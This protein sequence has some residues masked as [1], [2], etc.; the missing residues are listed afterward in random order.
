MILAMPLWV[1]YCRDSP[2]GCTR[3]KLRA[4]PN[5]LFDERLSRVRRPP[6]F[7]KPLNRESMTGDIRECI[8][9]SHCLTTSAVQ[10]CWRLKPGKRVMERDPQTPSA[11][12]AVVATSALCTK[13]QNENSKFTADMVDWEPNTWN[14]GQ[15]WGADFM[16]QIKMNIGGEG[17]GANNGGVK[18]LWDTVIKLTIGRWHWTEKVA[19]VEVTPNC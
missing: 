5:Q 13:T 2:S 17:T 10:R 3:V 14:V 4:H 7:S 16:F 11:G 1:A 15:S 12:G 9:L 8:L 19:V 6:S 18:P